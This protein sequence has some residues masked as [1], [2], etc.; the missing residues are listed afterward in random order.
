MGGDGQ[1]TRTVEVACPDCGVT[2][3]VQVRD[4][5]VIDDRGQPH[6]TL[7]VDKYEAW[8]HGLVC[9]GTKEDWAA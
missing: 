1:V 2:V 7:G 6:L 8:Q 4:E 5:L 9:E 3:P